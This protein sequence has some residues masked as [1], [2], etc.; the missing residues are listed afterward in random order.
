M[1]VYV[2]TCVP[3]SVRAC[4]QTSMHACLLLCMNV[5]HLGWCLTISDSICDND[6]DKEALFNVTYNVTDNISSRAILRHNNQH[7]R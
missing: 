4:M 1:Y 3:G 2:R 6:K 5:K 7:Y